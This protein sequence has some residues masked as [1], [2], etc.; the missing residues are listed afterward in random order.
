MGIVFYKILSTTK[1]FDSHG[2]Y[3]VSV[4]C[5]SFMSSIFGEIS[6]LGGFISLHKYQD[7][8]SQV[9]V[10]RVMRFE[11]FYQHHHPSGIFHFC[12]LTVISSSLPFVSSAM[13]VSAAVSIN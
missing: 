1:Y 6:T 12:G 7:I 9:N 4:F 8:G 11:L 13:R 10:K 2:S 3:L 5:V